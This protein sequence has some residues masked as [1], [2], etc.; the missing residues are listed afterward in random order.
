MVLYNSDKFVLIS[1]SDVSSEP[2]NPSE[3]RTVVTG[4]KGVRQSASSVLSKWH[5]FSILPASN[6]KQIMML[7]FEERITG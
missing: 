2:S 4:F 7:P 1:T 6:P 3:A 5:M